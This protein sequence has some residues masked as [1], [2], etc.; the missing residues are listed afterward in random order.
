MKLDGVFVLFS[1]S[2][3]VVAVS[4]HIVRAGYNGLEVFV[5]LKR[6][7]ILTVFVIQ[8]PVHR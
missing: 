4:Q 5:F 2:F 7:D 8:T 1:C 3:V 6:V